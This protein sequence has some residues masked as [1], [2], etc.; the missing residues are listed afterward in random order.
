MFSVVSVHQSGVLSTGDRVP[1]DHG[2]NCTG[3]PLPFAPASLT[4][5]APYCTE[6]TSALALSPPN[7]FKLDLTV[8]RAV[9]ILLE[10]FLVASI[11]VCFGR[12]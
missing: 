2:P 5:M 6:T 7:M 4:D 12:I 10:C 1:C 11:P 8:Q 3:T 9:C